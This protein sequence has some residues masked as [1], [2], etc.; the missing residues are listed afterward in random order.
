MNL[1]LGN[2]YDNKLLDYFEFEV[3]NYLPITYFTEIEID[4]CMKPVVIFQGDVFETDF[5]FERIK[6]FF[7]DFLIFYDIDDVNISDLKRVCIISAGDN[8]LIKFRSYQV[9]KVDPYLVEKGL[10]LKEVGPSLDLKVR[11]IKLA[12]SE[13][14]KLACKQPKVLRTHKAKNVETN[15][16]GEK[17]GRIHMGRQDVNEIPL[18]QYSKNIKKKKTAQEFKDTKKKNKEQNGEKEGK[19]DKKD[20]KP[21]AEIDIDL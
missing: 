20:K 12:S 19:K 8:K 14:Y 2:L 17:R 21:K 6:K 5:E 4:S 16:I 7:I 13:L 3:T 1:T 10:S 18:R 15:M 9:E 11:R